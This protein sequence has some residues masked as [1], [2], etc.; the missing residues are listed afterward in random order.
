MLCLFRSAQVCRE[1]KVLTNNRIT[2]ITE[3]TPKE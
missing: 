2:R 1:R 3:V